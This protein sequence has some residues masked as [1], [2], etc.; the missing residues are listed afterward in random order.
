MSTPSVLPRVSVPAG[1]GRHSAAPV[2]LPA[3]LYVLAGHGVHAT[4]LPGEYKPGAHARQAPT[5]LPPVAPAV[6]VPFGH[7][8]HWP[9]LTRLYVFA[10]HATQA[11]PRTLAVP[12][13]HAAQVSATPNVDAPAAHG[14]HAVTPVA[15]AV[16]VP[17]VQ[18][19]HDELPVLGPRLATVLTGHATQGSPTPVE[20][21]PAGHSV[22]A[23]ELVPPKAP[24]PLPAGHGVQVLL[25]GA[26]AN[27][28]AGHK[29]QPS[30]V[31]VVKLPAEQ[32]THAAAPCAPGPAVA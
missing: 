23:N 25:P 19:T 32:A 30:P 15:P 13:L 1:Q 28:L 10:T 22:H 29:V 8:V 24:V 26:D 31:P 14:V 4:P 5:S 12:A 17:A 7:A 9:L 3:A 20:T 6:S 18:L 27:V 16:S 2:P 11:P 21:V